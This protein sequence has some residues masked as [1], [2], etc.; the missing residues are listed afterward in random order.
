MQKK[1][2]EADTRDKL[3][4]Q[5]KRIEEA[6]RRADNLERALETKDRELAGMKR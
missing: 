2:W 1:Q 3:H 6:Q 4:A 5:Q